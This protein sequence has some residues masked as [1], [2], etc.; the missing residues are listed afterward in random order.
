MNVSLIDG[1][2]TPGCGIAC[3]PQWHDPHRHET[4]GLLLA[5][6]TPPTR[7]VR[8]GPLTVDL[9]TQRVEVEGVEIH[10][11]RREW[12]LLAYLA[13]NIGR[14]CRNEDV[15]RSSWGETWVNPRMA[16][17]SGKRY[18]AD[19]H[20]VNVARFRLRAKLGPA[21]AR[22]IS[23]KTGSPGCRLELVPAAPGMVGLG[24]RR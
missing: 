2:R 1:W 6:L 24:V 18:R 23:S 11:S 14:W 8:T 3:R 22:L 21:A 9:D 19:T 17:T 5:V 4:Y 13:E 20:L 12:G 16:V 15:L 10:L 7:I